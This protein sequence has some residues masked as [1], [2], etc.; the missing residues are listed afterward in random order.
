MTHIHIQYTSQIRAQVCS[1]SDPCN[2]NLSAST[3]VNA[4]LR[5][6]L[7]PSAPTEALSKMSSLIRMANRHRQ[8]DR[9]TNPTT[10]NF[11][12]QQEAIP[13]DFLQADL[14]VAQRRYFIFHAATLMSLLTCA[15]EWYVD[16]T[17]KAVG[18]PF[19]QLWTIHVFLKS[20]TQN[21]NARK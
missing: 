7:S 8:G 19:T 17:F 11:Y 21:V 20:G 12:I 16:G 3:I 4:A 13:E 9:P 10:L 14:Q 15:K 6:N 18:A 2:I 1:T 5:D